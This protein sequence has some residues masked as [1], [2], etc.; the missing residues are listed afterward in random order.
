[1]NYNLDELINI[2]EINNNFIHKVNDCYLT[3]AEIELLNKYGI[4]IILLFG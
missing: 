1:M 2:E 4:D 3:P